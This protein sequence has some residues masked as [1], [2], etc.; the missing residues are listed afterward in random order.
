[1]P[2]ENS[3]PRPPAPT[4][5]PTDRPTQRPTSRPTSSSATECVFAEV[6]N[7]TQGC[8]RTSSNGEGTN[9]YPYTSPNVAACQADCALRADCTGI[10]YHAWESKCEIHT[11]PNDFDHTASV[12]GC[13]CFEKDCG[14]RRVR[15]EAPVIGSGGDA[16]S[17]SFAAALAAVAIAVLVVVGKVAWTRAHREPDTVVV[18]APN[19][20]WDESSM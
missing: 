15:G 14:G 2:C 11:S 7:P 10:E 13:F 16:T 18:E 3:T 12:A 17:S 4:A 8:C 6:V 9:N 1:M 20:E 19:L 5:R